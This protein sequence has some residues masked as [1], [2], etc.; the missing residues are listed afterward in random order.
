MLIMKGKFRIYTGNSGDT[1]FVRNGK[2]AVNG[3]YVTGNEAGFEGALLTFLLM[4][5]SQLSV[6]G[7]WHANAMDLF[8]DTG[9]MIT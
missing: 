6:K 8:E 7:P 2:D 9:V 4:D 5:G 1:W 3:I